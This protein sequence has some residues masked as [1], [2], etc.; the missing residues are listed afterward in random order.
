[1]VNVPS[2]NN[3]PVSQRIIMARG[4]A[5]AIEHAVAAVI[6]EGAVRTYDMGGS[7]STTDMARAVA[8]QLGAVV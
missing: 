3:E 5:N 2:D 4:K 1:M 8:A 6:G 7:A